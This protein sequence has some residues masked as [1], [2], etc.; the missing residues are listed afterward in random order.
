ML[1]LKTKK[2]VIA[3]EIALQSEAVSF[4]PKSVAY[5]NTLCIE[6][7]VVNILASW[8]KFTTTKTRDSETKRRRDVF[9]RPLVPKSW[10]L[11][12]MTI[13][14]CFISLSMYARKMAKEGEGAV[15]GDGRAV[16]DRTVHEKQ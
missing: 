14:V 12:A 3:R 5:I 4:I 15:I 2:V 13:F 8:L 7:A 1:Q 10:V 9:V 11:V 16:D 6:Q